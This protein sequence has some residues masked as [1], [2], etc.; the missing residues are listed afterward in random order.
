MET[1]L[2]RAQF[3]VKATKGRTVVG[4]A[5]T[6]DLDNSGDV[7]QPGAYSRWLEEWK[8][9]GKP[10][11]LLDN[12]R[13]ES[14]ES[15]LGVMT[16]AEETTKGLRAEFQIVDGPRGD[17]LLNQIKIRAINS[18]SIGYQTRAYRPPTEGEAKLGVRRV[19]E[20]I[21]LR[22]VSAVL[23]PANE[24]AMIEGIKA[25][26]LEPL[27]T[28]L[29]ELKDQPIELRKLNTYIGNLLKKA[30]PEDDSAEVPD[31]HVDDPPPDATPEPSAASQTATD[32]AEIRRAELLRELKLRQLMGEK[33]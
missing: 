31:D 19:L 32:D 21:D 15:A 7:V 18:F 33:P 29:A 30:P 8:A 17:H 20:D 4:L 5:S 23:F 22:E 14:T 10:I 9:S 3:D 6:W 25:G 28:A 16:G 26:D 11:S 12:H 24:N 2:S 27:R 1:T 13:Y